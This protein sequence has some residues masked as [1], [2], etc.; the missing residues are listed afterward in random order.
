[1]KYVIAAGAYKYNEP[2]AKIMNNLCIIEGYELIEK[3][4]RDTSLTMKY[5]I[6]VDPVSKVYT[7]I[8]LLCDNYFK[9]RM[10]DKNNNERRFY[11]IAKRLPMDLQM[12]LCHRLFNSTKQSVSGQ[13]F[14]EQGKLLLC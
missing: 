9:L 10:E 7:S 2:E 12:L 13:L 5:R 3:Y 6:E 1:M 11:T 8:V 14:T 4:L